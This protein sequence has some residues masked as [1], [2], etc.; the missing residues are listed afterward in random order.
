MHAL[1]LLAL[2]L[3]ATLRDMATILETIALFQ[4]LVLGVWP[5]DPVGLLAG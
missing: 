2:A 1:Q 5:D 4:G 3:L